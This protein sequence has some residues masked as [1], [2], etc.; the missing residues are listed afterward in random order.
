MFAEK[1]QSSK[2]DTDDDI[3][4]IIDKFDSSGKRVFADEGESLAIR[5]G[6][7]RDNDA[8]RGITRGQLKLKGF[9]V[10]CLLVSAFLKTFSFEVAAFFSEC[11]DSIHNAIINHLKLLNDGR[12]V[13]SF[14]VAGSCT[15]YNLEHILGWRFCRQPVAFLLPP[16]KI[17]RCW[18]TVVPS[19]RPHVR[20]LDSVL[21]L[22]NSHKKFSGARLWLTE[23]S[24]STWINLLLQES[25]SGPMER[26][27]ASPTIFQIESTHPGK[28]TA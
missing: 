1:L 27:A 17:C 18:F 2:F 15:E 28:L 25:R 4:N 23:Q 22:S 8:A 6:S 19:R 26:R 16:P 11:I 12:T 13:S 10:S 14:S 21:F 5:F 3:R 9:V 24:H 20:F 7:P